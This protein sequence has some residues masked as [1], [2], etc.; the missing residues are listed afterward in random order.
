M[1]QKI[2]LKQQSQDKKIK[3][4]CVKKLLEESLSL[5]L[6]SFLP[7]VYNES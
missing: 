3:K 4:N 5:N 7:L 1:K 2:N 6:K